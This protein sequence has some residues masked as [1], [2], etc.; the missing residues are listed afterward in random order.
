MPEIHVRTSADLKGFRDLQ[1]EM[2]KL[3]Q[4]AERYSTLMRSADRVGGALAAGGG[5]G[6]LPHPPSGMSQAQRRGGVQTSGGLRYNLDTPSGYAQYMEQ[7]VGPAQSMMSGR[8]GGIRN[9]G[10]IRYQPVGMTTMPVSSEQI[11]NWFLGLASQIG[12]MDE[13]MRRAYLNAGLDA[14][15]SSAELPPSIR[16]FYQQ[17]GS[18]WGGP[19]PQSVPNSPSLGARFLQ[20]FTNNMR[21]NSLG[22]ALMGGLRGAIGGSLIDM[23]I[24]GSAGDAMGGMGAAALGGYMG[25][26]VG[27]IAGLILQ[28][29]IGWVTGQLGQGV[30]TWQQTIPVFSQLSHA[31]DNAKNS[32]EGFRIATQMAGAALG[33]SATQSTQAAQTLTQSFGMSLG[34]RGITN[35][36]RQTAQAA[37]LNGLDPQTIAAIEATA[38]QLGITNGVGASMNNTQFNG[39]LLNMTQQANMQG[40]QGPFYTG[41][42]SIY[43]QLGS[44]NPIITSANTTAAIYTAMNASG[45]QG[46]QAQAGANILNQMNASIASGQGLSG[47]MGMAA[48]Y[49]ASGGRITNPWQMRAIQEQGLGAA[50]GNTTLGAQLLKMVR[51]MGGGNIYTQAG[52][53]S[54]IT[55]ISENQAVEMIRSGALNAKSISEYS[56]QSTRLTTSD[57]AN[58]GKAVLNVQASRVGYLQG[59]LKSAGSGLA[60]VPTS[61]TLTSTGSLYRGSALQNQQ[62]QAQQK[63]IDEAMKQG[64]RQ[65]DVDSYQLLTAIMESIVYQES[66]GNIYAINDNTDGKK[67][68]SQHSRAAYLAM[69]HKLKGKQLALGPFQL[70]N[71]HKGVT[72]ESAINLPWAAQEAL[73]ILLGNK[74]PATMSEADWQRA[75]Y[76]YSGGSSTYPTAV[77]TRATKYAN[78]PN[79][80]AVDLSPATIQAIKQAVK[81]LLLERDMMTG[82]GPTH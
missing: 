52:L 46:L 25:G 44:V 59:L 55:G 13:D 26:P 73:S 57:L 14:R 45:I 77:L 38:A 33:M 37:L 64:L 62:T 78:D 15:N 81:E 74:N 61:T 68:V 21:G 53:L 20:H 7:V 60:G 79:A 6:V 54:S 28:K 35:L 56:D 23:A 65:Q 31:L 40:R 49:Q 34:T 8:R 43:S 27:A 75:L 5:S 1:A 41:L 76:N 80:A 10:G 4:L 58:A 12:K 67:D 32:A 19:Q 51:S 36:V 3:I 16:Q 11:T 69:A 70:E 9:I 2:S 63:L 82:K 24:G 50:I 71:F 22:G 18:S 17:Y 66:R 29:T 72:P 30:Q 47:I 39:M 42:M 48:I